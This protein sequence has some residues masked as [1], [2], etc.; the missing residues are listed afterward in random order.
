MS[1]LNT[2]TSIFYFVFLFVSSMF[3]PLDALPADYRM[4]VLLTDLEDFSYREVAEILDG[5]H[6]DLPEQAF[7]MVGTIDEAVA[8]AACSMRR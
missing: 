1:L 5:A 6:D 7:Y 2:V 3:Y 4:V 8:G